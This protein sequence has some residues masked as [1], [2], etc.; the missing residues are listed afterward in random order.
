MSLR[1][2]FLLLAV[3]LLLHGCGY[4][5]VKGPGLSGPAFPDRGEQEGRSRL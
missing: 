4:K 2:A 5:I 3:I 1:K